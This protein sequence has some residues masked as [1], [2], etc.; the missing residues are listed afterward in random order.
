MAYA[1]HILLPNSKI[2]YMSQILVKLS[3]WPIKTINIDS[4]AAVTHNFAEAQSMNIRNI[5]TTQ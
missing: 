1:P 3:Y 2:E 5:I 4:S